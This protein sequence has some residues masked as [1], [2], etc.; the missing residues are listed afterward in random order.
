MR[1]ITVLCLVAVFNSMLSA[2]QR[3]V[4]QRAYADDKQVVHLVTAD[5]HDRRIAPE[6]GQAGVERIQVAADGKTV[7]W[8]VD[9]WQSCCQSYPLPTK[10]VLWRSGRV[11]RRMD[12]GRPCWGWVFENDGEELA[13]R[14]SFTHGGWSGESTLIDVA[15]GK[16]LAS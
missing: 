9:N 3:P 14:T 2:G 12:T 11:L 5:G 16:T 15:S 13:Y 7:G 10:L 8:L 1:A 6:K 4:V